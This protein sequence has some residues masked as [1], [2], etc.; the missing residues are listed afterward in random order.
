MSQSKA[1]QQ[2]SPAPYRHLKM[3]VSSFLGTRKHGGL[4]RRFKGHAGHI[5]SAYIPLAKISHM[6]SSSSVAI[7]TRVK[8]NRIRWTSNIGFIT[9]SFGCKQLKLILA[10][11]CANL[12]NKH[13]GM[14]QNQGKS[15]LKSG[16]TLVPDLSSRTCIFL[17]EQR[18][19]LNSAWKSLPIR[20]A[21]IHLPYEPWTN[22]EK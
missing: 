16:A 21:Y 15:S 9:G 19:P 8:I 14:L 17:T 5:A 4:H 20:V 2:R 1:G 6:S 11:F 12:L 18:Q 7:C 10:G 3:W 13:W 22:W